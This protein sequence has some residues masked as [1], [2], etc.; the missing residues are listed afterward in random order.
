M[1]KYNTAYAAD[2]PALIEKADAAEK[3]LNLIATT[4]TSESEASRKYF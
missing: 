3:E 4:V 2:A 1:M